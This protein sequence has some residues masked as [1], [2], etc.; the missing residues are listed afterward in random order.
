MAF[1]DTTIIVYTLFRLLNF[2]EHEQ[3]LSIRIIKQLTT[4][5][6]KVLNVELLVM[7]IE[8]DYRMPLIDGR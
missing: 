1:S 2:A 6:I 3:L 8:I 5:C 7:L 4:K